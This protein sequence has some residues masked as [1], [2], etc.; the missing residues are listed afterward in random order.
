MS[1]ENGFADVI[2][3]DPL[4]AEESPVESSETLGGASNVCEFNENVTL[5]ERKIERE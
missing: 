4:S 3:S 1:F 2:G 5:L